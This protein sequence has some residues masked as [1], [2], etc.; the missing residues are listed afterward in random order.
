M[1]D[2]SSGRNPATN[3]GSDSAKHHVG[4]ASAQYGSTPKAAPS[5]PTTAPTGSYVR[6][7]KPTS[8]PGSAERS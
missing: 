5:V 8:T 7:E 6:D 1:A 2:S 3:A 4:T